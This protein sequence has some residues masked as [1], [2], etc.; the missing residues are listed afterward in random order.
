MLRRSGQDISYLGAGDD[1]LYL[2][3]GCAHDLAKLCADALQYSQAVVLGESGEEVLDGFVGV[4]GANVL[5]QLSDD[6]ALV[7]GGERR[8]A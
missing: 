8:R 3:T 5:L 4:C 6:G 7:F 2:A 1:H